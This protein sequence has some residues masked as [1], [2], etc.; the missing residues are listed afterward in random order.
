MHRQVSAKAAQASFQKN[1]PHIAVT[2]SPAGLL[3]LTGMNSTWFYLKAGSDFLGCR[4]ANKAVDSIPGNVGFFQ[5]QLEMPRKTVKGGR[6]Y[7]EPDI[8]HAAQ[9]GHCLNIGM[10]PEKKGLLSRLSSSS[11]SSKGILYLEPFKERLHTAK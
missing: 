1:L 2:F 7:P 8:T 5:G 3:S 11:P 9:C 4:K 10:H 6:K